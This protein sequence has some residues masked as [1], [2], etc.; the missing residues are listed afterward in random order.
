MTEPQTVEYKQIWKDD[1]LKWP[2]LM[3]NS[4][5][6]KSLRVVERA[7]ANGKGWNIEIRWSKKGWSLAGAEMMNCGQCN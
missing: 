5:N 6:G 2:V 4:A 7:T 3:V 1:Y